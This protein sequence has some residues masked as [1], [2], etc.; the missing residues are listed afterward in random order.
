MTL[1]YCICGVITI[2]SITIL[3]QTRWHKVW[4]HLELF[5]PK[6]FRLHFPCLNLF[7]FLW[8]ELVRPLYHVIFKYLIDAHTNGLYGFYRC[9]WF[10][11]KYALYCYYWLFDLLLLLP[12]LLLLCSSFLFSDGLI[13]IH[14]A[15][16]VAPNT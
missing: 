6:H 5:S 16:L 1:N 11:L 4:T 3:L 9:C 14:L 8:R 15:L 10:A 7:P 2:T 12:L 13:K